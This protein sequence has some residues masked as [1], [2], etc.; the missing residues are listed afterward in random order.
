MSPS[1]I[2]LWPLPQRQ[3]RSAACYLAVDDG[4]YYAVVVSGGFLHYLQGQN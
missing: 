2:Y 4:D 1:S 3:H